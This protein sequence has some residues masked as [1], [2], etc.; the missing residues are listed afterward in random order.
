MAPRSSVRWKRSRPRRSRKACAHDVLP[1]VPEKTEQAHG[2]Q[3]LEGIGGKVYVMGT[4]RSRGKPCPK[5]GEF[6]PEG[7][8]T[9]QTP[10]IPDVMAFLPPRPR[11]GDV[12][13]IFVFWE[14]KASDGRESDEQVRF[15]ELCQDALVEHVVGDYNALI[16]WL[17]ARL[18]VK[19]DSFSHYRQPKGSSA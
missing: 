7:Q 6:V 10:G 11:G 16:A 12:R 4:R 17:I 3:L 2:V 1:R 13:P 19:A 9:R 15:K 5:C 14:A 8:T 18:Y